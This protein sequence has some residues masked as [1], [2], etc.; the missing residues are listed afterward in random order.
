MYTSAHTN[1]LITLAVSGTGTGTRT[2]TW[3]NRLYDLYR[4][5]HTTPEEG[6]GST[7]LSPIV[8]VLTSVPASVSDTASVI[9][10]VHRQVSVVLG[11]SLSFESWGPNRASERPV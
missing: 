10:P 9:T 11:M 1:G 4:T 8:L 6:Q 5:F 2:V 7:L 3:M